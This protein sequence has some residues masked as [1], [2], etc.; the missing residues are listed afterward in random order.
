M[1]IELSIIKAYFLKL[2]GMLHTN[3]RTIFLFSY[4][5]PIFVSS[6]TLGYF[7]LALEVLRLLDKFGTLSQLPSKFPVLLMLV[8]LDPNSSVLPNYWDL[9]EL[10]GEVH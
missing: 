7:L 4:P 10:R 8:V 1:L 3:L 6:R 9:A 5:S 2:K